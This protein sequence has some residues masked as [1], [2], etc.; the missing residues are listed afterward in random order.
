MLCPSSCVMTPF[1]GFYLLLHC[2][3]Q[4]LRQRQS[5]FQQ[6]KK[7][8]HS[9]GAKVH[10]SN[11]PHLVQ[12]VFAFPTAFRQAFLLYKFSSSFHSKSFLILYFCSCFWT[13]ESRLLRQLFQP[14]HIC[15]P[16]LLLLNR[17][18]FTSSFFY[19]C[20]P[21]GVGVENQ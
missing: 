17:K 16:L 8:I 4:H 18:V 10:S 20:L 14:L 13:S 19:M 6:H 9:P 12:Y 5:S 21:L 15:V 11:L 2:N 1:L 3:K 7:Q